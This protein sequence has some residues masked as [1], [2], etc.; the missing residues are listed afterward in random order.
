M[1]YNTTQE[2]LL[3]PEYGRLIQQMVDH[4]QTITDRITRQAY[5]ERIIGVM[6]NMNPQMKNVPD[7]HQKLWNHLALMTDYQ[8]DIDYPVEITRQTDSYK[9]SKLVYPHH[10]I[11]YRHYGNLVEQLVAD[12]EKMPE[13]EERDN[14]VLLTTGRM[15]RNL[16]DWKGDG[17]ENEKVARDLENYTHG[18]IPASE[19]V[20]LMSASFE[21]NKGKHYQKN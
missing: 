3:M 6:G 4:V 15:K 5:A 21:M 13:G 1:D 18:V 12:L 16:A 17:V 7:Y 19:T 10:D 20:E 2:K 11:H 9:P 8:L 14:L